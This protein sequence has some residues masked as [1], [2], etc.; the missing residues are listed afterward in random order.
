[1]VALAMVATTSGLI[2]SVF[3]VSRMLAMLTDMSGRQSGFA[4]RS[5]YS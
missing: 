4:G 1:M 5:F 3:A 2:A